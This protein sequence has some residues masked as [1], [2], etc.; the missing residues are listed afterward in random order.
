MYSDEISPL[1]R[2]TSPLRLQKNSPSSEESTK[3]GSEIEINK[4]HDA[5][6]DRL[7]EMMK[8]IDSELDFDSNSDE[9]LD[10]ELINKVMNSL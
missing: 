7:A 4:H 8:V 6:L 2:P 5:S 1:S 9:D 10:C 3:V